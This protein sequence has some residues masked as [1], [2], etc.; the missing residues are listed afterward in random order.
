MAQ[1]PPEPGGE[2]DTCGATA[3][4]G[5]IGQ[6]ESVLQ[7]MVFAGPL[8][9]IRPG[10]AVTMDYSAARLNVSLDAGGRIVRVTCG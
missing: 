3:L 1:M 6:P 10:Q 4:Q 2:V 9:V 7:G 8:R 5:L